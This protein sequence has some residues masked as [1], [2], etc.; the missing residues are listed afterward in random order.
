LRAYRV[1]PRTLD[2]ARQF[3]T[4]AQWHSTRASRPRHHWPNSLSLRLHERETWQDIADNK[5]FLAKGKLP[6]PVLC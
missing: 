4:A 5:A 3:T 2:V 6:M 1:S